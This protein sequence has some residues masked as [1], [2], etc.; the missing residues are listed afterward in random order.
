MRSSAMLNSCYQGHGRVSFLW[1]SVKPKKV[2]CC[3]RSDR[4]IVAL[5]ISKEGERRAEI[6]QKIS[7]H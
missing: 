6:T 7:V 2:Q 3:G 1:L 4:K 5:K